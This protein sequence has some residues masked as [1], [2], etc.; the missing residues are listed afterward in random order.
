MGG[1]PAE[2]HPTPQREEPQKERGSRAIEEV[3]A[4]RRKDMAFH[5]TA[6]FL[7][8]SFPE[9]VLLTELLLD[10][11][12]AGYVQAPPDAW[13]L[14]CVVAIGEILL[15]DCRDELTI[16]RAGRYLAGKLFQ[17]MADQRLT[18]ELPG[19]AS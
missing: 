7:C 16:E 6:N 12:I 4:K 17:A 10:D 14:E 2:H 15:Q 3:W 11:T 9:A 8:Y 13:D 18:E 1:S 5:K 19:K